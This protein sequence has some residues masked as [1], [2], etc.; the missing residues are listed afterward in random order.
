MPK[1]S[2][3]N[4]AAA[5]LLKG[6]KSPPDPRFLPVLQL[7]RWGLENQAPLTS[8]GE[9]SRE[10]LEQ[11]LDLLLDAPEEAVMWHF[12]DHDPAVEADPTASLER[13]K[14]LAEELMEKGALEGAS[15]LLDRLTDSLMLR[16][17]SLA[18]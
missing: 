5:E 2:P 17:P 6:E 18:P 1:S 7:A 11:A 16:N 15:L 12:R 9:R 14:W 8:P 10:T 3:L 13:E 4:Q